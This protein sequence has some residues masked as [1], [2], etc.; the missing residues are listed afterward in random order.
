MFFKHS[1]RPGFWIVTIATKYMV[2]SAFSHTRKKRSSRGLQRFSNHSP[3]I[4]VHS[5]FLQ[6]ALYLA[7][8]SYSLIENGYS[9]TVIRNI[10]VLC[11]LGLWA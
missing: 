5:T 11:H 1:C 6:N 8:F 3:N 4:N 7:Q 10:I 2:S 9:C